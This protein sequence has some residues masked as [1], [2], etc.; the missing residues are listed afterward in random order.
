MGTIED[1]KQMLGIEAEKS[2]MEVIKSFIEKTMNE[3]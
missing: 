2:I 3:L 1:T